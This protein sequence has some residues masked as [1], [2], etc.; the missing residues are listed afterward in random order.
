MVVLAR[1]YYAPEDF[2]D[3]GWIENGE[4]EAAWAALVEHLQQRELLSWSGMCDPRFRGCETCGVSGMLSV[5]DEGGE[6]WLV[7]DALWVL[8]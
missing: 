2:T 8:S 1:G 4:V 6:E 3:E 5:P 7:A